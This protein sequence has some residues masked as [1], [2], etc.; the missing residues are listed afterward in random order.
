MPAATPLA[1]LAADPGLA[2][3]SSWHRGCWENTIV[4]SWSQGAALGVGSELI[5]FSGE[6]T[7]DKYKEIAH[8][9]G[10]DKN[11]FSHKSQ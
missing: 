1:L 7:G 3:K 9:S 4:K 10:R 8:E 2:A 11:M 6:N 5:S